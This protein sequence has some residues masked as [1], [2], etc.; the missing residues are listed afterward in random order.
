MISEQQVLHELRAVVVKPE[1]KECVLP[2][3]GR[4]S[5]GDSCRTVLKQLVDVYLRLLHLLV[6]VHSHVEHGAHLTIFVKGLNCA[7]CFFDAL[8][9]SLGIAEEGPAILR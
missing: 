7:L 5:S 6:D 3:S 8:D 9:L 1:V 2:G 4:P